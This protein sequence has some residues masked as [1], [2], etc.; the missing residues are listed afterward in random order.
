MLFKDPHPEDDQDILDIIDELIDTDP[1]G[2]S[3]FL[4][5]AFSGLRLLIQRVL[6]K[7]RAS[8]AMILILN[9]LLTTRRPMLARTSNSLLLM[10][11]VHSFFGE[12]EGGL[13]PAVG[14]QYSRS[15]FEPK[16]SSHPCSTLPSCYG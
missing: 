16:A 3:K 11:R 7:F 5:S 14:V 10:D 4:S 13:L 8:L 1:Y 6:Q 12:Y 9:R 15:L 2:A